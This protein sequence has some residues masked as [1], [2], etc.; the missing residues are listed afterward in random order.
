MTRFETK[1]VGLIAVGLMAG[2]FVKFGL[3]AL[4]VSCALI[5]RVA[6]AAAD[7]ESTNEEDF[8]GGSRGNKPVFIE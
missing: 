2:K 8:R 4:I 1:F 6:E 5:V 7:H 3:T